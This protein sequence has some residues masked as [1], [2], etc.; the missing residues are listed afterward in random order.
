ME[1]VKS[2]AGTSPSFTDT[3]ADYWQQRWAE[4][5]IQF[6]KDQIHP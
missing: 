3:H 6:H 1:D 2:A 5:Q 4:N